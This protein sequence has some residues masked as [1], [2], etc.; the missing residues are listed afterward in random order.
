MEK[1]LAPGSFISYKAAWSFVDDVQ[2]VANELEKIIESEPERAARLYESFIAA[3]HEKAEEI[4]DS[5]GSFGMLVEELFRG[6]IG[7]RQAAGAD[8]DETAKSLLAWM[9]DDPYGFC[10]DLDREAVKVL[11]EEGL[12]AFALQVRGRIEAAAKSA[13]DEKASSSERTRHRWGE[14]L[15]TILAAQRDTD[16]YIALCEERG[17]G[18]EECKTIAHMYRSKKR[19]AEALSWVEHGLEIARSSSPR[20]FADHELGEMKRDLQA[21]L[22][23]GRDAFESAWVEFERHPSTFSYKTLMRY[24]PAGEKKAWHE[25][26]MEASEKGDLSLQIELWLEKKEINRLVE[27]LRRATDE[28]LER[29]SHFTTEPAARKLERS[30]P[31]VAARVYRALAMRVV[32]AGKSKYYDAALDNLEKARK[33]YVKGKIESEWA[34]LVAYIRERHSRKSGFMADF[35]RIASGAPKPTE[36]T[37]LERAK[38]RWPKGGKK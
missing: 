31:E 34:G 24:T 35:E 12:A 37:F 29:L 8:R 23:H 11:D 3:C 21:K 30:H 6:W 27:R 5:S 16:G 18:V 19:P 15:K 33:C 20:P 17:L 26:A 32:N 22:G 38:K 28:E 2:E 10:H 1:A 7:A 25:K 36:Q 9:E 13:K 14:V 4:D